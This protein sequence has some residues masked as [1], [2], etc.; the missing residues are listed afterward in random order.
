MISRNFLFQMRIEF[1]FFYTPREILFLL[2]RW[3]SYCR[4]KSSFKNCT[5]NPLLNLTSHYL[6]IISR[7]ILPY[8]LLLVAK[9]LHTHIHVIGFQPFTDSKVSVSWIRRSFRLLNNLHKN[10]IIQTSKFIFSSVH[11]IYFEIELRA[12]KGGDGTHDN[13]H[14]DDSLFCLLVRC[15]RCDRD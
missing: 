5:Q 9:Y 8:S 1:K 2:D 3:G 11:I 10:F 13:S 12:L 7:Q 6:Q 15:L 4:K 14:H